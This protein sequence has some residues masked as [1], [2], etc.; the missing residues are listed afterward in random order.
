MDKFQIVSRTTQGYPLYF[1][2]FGE[3][4]SLIGLDIETVLFKFEELVRS[5]GNNVHEYAL[6]IAKAEIKNR[7]ERACE[8]RLRSTHHIHEKKF[9]DPELTRELQNAEIQIAR[10]FCRDGQD[11]NWGIPLDY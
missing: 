2:W 1:R 3:P 8:G 7:I 5:K 6:I 4:S 11:S 9:N 10:N